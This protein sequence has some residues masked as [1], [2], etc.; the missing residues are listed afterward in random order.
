MLYSFKRNDKVFDFNL[1]CKAVFLFNFIWLG[2]TNCNAE[3]LQGLNSNAA[4]ILHGMASNTAE[5]LR[6]LTS[7]AAEILRALTSSAV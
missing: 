1:L 4:E 7:S 2:I 5:I 3:I 6:G